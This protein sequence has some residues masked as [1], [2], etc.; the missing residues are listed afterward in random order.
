MSRQPDML[1][2]LNDDDFDSSGNL[3]FANSECDYQILFHEFMGS[4]PVY[5]VLSKGL[6]GTFDRTVEGSTQIVRARA[7]DV[8]PDA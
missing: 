1:T 4:R 7:R 3:V 8:S 6:C 5:R 2:S